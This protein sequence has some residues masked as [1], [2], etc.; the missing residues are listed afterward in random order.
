MDDRRDPRP[1]GEPAS[2]RV[3]VIESR[4]AATSA[5]LDLKRELIRLTERAQVVESSLTVERRQRGEALAEVETHKGREAAAQERAKAAEE[6]AKAAEERTKIA[7]VRAKTS[8]GRSRTAEDRAKMTEDRANAAIE[9]AKKAEDRAK[10]SEDQA[11]VAE[12]EARAAEERAITAEEH[13]KVSHERAKAAEERAITAEE[14]AKA[15]EER[16]RATE[17]RA[18]AAEERAKASEDRAK[19]AEDRARATD[20]L[21]RAAEAFAMEAEDRA[22]AAEQQAEAEKERADA[23]EAA[24]AA[25]SRNLLELH[26]EVKTAFSR[27]PSFAPPPPSA[28]ETAVDQLG[29]EDIPGPA[30]MPRMSRSKPPSQAPSQPL[31]PLSQPPSIPSPASQPPSEPPKKVVEPDPFPSIRPPPPAIYSSPP[32]P[33]RLPPPP[34]PRPKLRSNP[35]DATPAAPGVQTVARAVTPRPPPVVLDVPVAMGSVD[36]PIVTAPSMSRSTP[37]LA[38][39]DDEWSK[40]MLLDMPLP[41]RQER[42]AL[43]RELSDPESALAAVVALKGR[44]WL[45]GLPPESLV[46]DLAAI[47]Y[48]DECAVFEIARGWERGAMSQSVVIHLQAETDGK[49]REHDAWLVQHLGAATDCQAI[50]DIAVRREEATAT[51]IW[52]LKALARLAAAHS[53]DWQEL[54]TPMMIIAFDPDATIRDGATAVIDALPKGDE[55]RRILLDILR[56]DDDENVLSRAIQAIGGTLPIEIGTALAERLLSHRSPRVQDAVRDLI[57]LARA[58]RS[59]MPPP[60]GSMPPGSSS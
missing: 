35:P 30:A 37:E 55:K 29:V 34:T 52:L 16:A 10:A 33:Q 42:D 31:R 22:K 23:S 24:E 41:V 8:E 53:I 51:R 9:R 54:L 39:L 5:V 1:E 21:A 50:C 60:R 7:E 38:S 40:P 25:I 47:D 57:A 46:N 11:K 15:T 44:D 36:P 14:R 12:D 48:D 20:V 32:P 19:A 18:K 4:N 49:R 45:R 2:K 27:I 58:R 56:K 17:E 59:Q 3:E 26:D 13:A 6:R 28:T 43:L